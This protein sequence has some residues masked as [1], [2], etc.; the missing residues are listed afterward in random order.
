MSN[1]NNSGGKFALGALLGAA[2][3]AV[4]AYLTAPK[5]GKETREDIKK[6]A[7][8]LKE[9]AAKKTSEVL[10]TTS[11]K[12]DELRDKAGDIAEDVAHV[13]HEAEQNT[14]EALGQWKD[15]AANTIEGAKEGFD[16]KPLGRNKR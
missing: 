14:R 5:S 1:S 11:K 10:D 6:R 12:V 4:A 15:R 16:K 8:E 9:T 7:G 2:V 13:A 3:G